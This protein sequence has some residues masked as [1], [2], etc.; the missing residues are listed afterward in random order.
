MITQ[1]LLKLQK[2]IQKVSV[3]STSK[4]LMKH[5]L[6]TQYIWGIILLHT[7]GNLM[8]IVAMI[9]NKFRGLTKRVTFSREHHQL[10]DCLTT[11]LMIRLVWAKVVEQST[12]FSLSSKDQPKLSQS[13]KISFVFNWIAPPS[14]YYLNIAGRRN[15]FRNFL[16]SNFTTRINIKKQG[17]NVYSRIF[18]WWVLYSLWYFLESTVCTFWRYNQDCF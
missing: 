6:R 16:V 14:A 11:N 8:W 15:D 12:L 10:F 7:E 13:H 1:P 3:G 9:N 4:Q 17:G 2:V 5:C 18:K